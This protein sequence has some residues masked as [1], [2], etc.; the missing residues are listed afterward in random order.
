MIKVTNENRAEF[1]SLYLEHVLNSAVLDRLVIITTDELQ[2]HSTTG[3][4]S[5]PG[6][7]ATL[8]RLSH[9]SH[10]YESQSRKLIDGATLYLDSFNVWKVSSKLKILFPY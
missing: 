10:L 7:A 6:S 8:S 1:V 9:S 3:L 5:D 4:G 2:P